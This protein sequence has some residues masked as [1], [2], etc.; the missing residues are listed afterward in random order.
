MLVN[1]LCRIWPNSWFFFRI[2][3]YF[4][5]V[6]ILI[7]LHYLVD[8]LRQPVLPLQVGGPQL[9]EVE[10]G[11]RYAVRLSPHQVPDVLEPG[12]Q[13]SDLLLELPLRHWARHR[14]TNRRLPNGLINN[15]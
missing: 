6:T 4:L 9:A 8:I 2:I 14:S 10:L 3:I 12:P 5:C 15:G 7:S 13:L 1:F 11:R